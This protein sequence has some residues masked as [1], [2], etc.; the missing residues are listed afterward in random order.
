MTLPNRRLLNAGGFLVC[1]GMMGFALFAQHVLLL[2]PCPLCVLQRL[3]VISLGLVFLVAALHNPQGWGSRVYAALLF[4]VAGTG[5][6]I[7]GW[8]VRLQSLPASEVPACG[9]GLDYMIDNFPLGEAL[10]MVFKGSGECAEVV[11]SFLGLS[12]PS[13]VLVWMLGLGGAGIWNNL[14]RQ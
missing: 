1:A 10:S 6:G 7:A 11:W 4:V 13:W 5:A 2:E 9:P 14:R 8:H 12:M 3:V